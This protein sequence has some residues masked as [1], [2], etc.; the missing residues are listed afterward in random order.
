MHCSHEDAAENN[1]EEGDGTVCGSHYS[2]EDWTQSGNIEELYYIYFPG[3]ENPV[4][5]AVLHLV[6]GRAPLWV[7]SKE[8]LHISAVEM[9]CGSQ[10]YD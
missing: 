1:P 6:C 3:W 7:A 10:R 5:H 9:V 2:S 4:I 8:P